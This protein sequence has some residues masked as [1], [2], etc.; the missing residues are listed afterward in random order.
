MNCEVR[1]DGE[2]RE[3][4]L[5]LNFGDKMQ[6]ELTSELKDGRCSGRVNGLVWVLYDTLHCCTTCSDVVL[7]G[8]KVSRKKTFANLMV[9]WL[10]VKVFS[11]KFGGVASLVQ[12]KRAICESFLGKIVFFTNSRKFS[13]TSIWYSRKFVARDNFCQFAGHFKFCW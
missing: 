9:L 11:A 3:L 2:K 4:F 5:R 6:R 7:Y 12:Q 13:A 8:G 10:F 1:W